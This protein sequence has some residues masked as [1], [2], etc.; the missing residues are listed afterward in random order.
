MKKAFAIALVL[1]GLVGCSNKCRDGGR[2]GYG[3]VG[4]TNYYECEKE[5]CREQ[6]P[7]KCKC[8]DRCSCNHG[9]AK[10]E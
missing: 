5:C 6:D 2:A 3:F 4:M 9:A 10:S 7:K 8:S 1:L